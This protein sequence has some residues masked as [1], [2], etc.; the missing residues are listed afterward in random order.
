MPLLLLLLLWWR[1]VLV[2]VRTMMLLTKNR[3]IWL[4]SF[5]STR[6]KFNYIFIHGYC[7]LKSLSDARHVIIAPRVHYLERPM[8]ISVRLPNNASYR[9]RRVPPYR[10]LPL[11]AF[12]ERPRPCSRVCRSDRQS[13]SLAFVHPPAFVHYFY[14]TMVKIL[15]VIRSCVAVLACK[16]RLHILMRTPWAFLS[17]RNDGGSIFHSFFFFLW[18]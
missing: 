13:V 6:L 10:F 17:V 11:Y 15:K 7:C 16:N 14:L 2:L 18:I 4:H 3:R 9:H 1:V 8:F 5:S 12:L